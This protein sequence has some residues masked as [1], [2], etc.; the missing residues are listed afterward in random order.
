MKTRDQ[1]AKEGNKR[2]KD[3][4]YF[5]LYVESA[6]VCDEGKGRSTGGGGMVKEVTEGKNM[7]PVEHTRMKMCNETRFCTLTKV[8][9]NKNMT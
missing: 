5:L 9:N 8:S 3:V 2:K 6:S 1:G 7:S 4:S